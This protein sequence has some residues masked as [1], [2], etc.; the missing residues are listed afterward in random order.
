M[1]G[2]RPVC[3]QFAGRGP[4]RGTGGSAAFTNYCP[5]GLLA[6][7]RVQGLTNHCGTGESARPGWDRPRLAAGNGGR[8]MTIIRGSRTR[9][10]PGIAAAAFLAVLLPAGLASAA[11]ASAGSASAGS[12]A[13]AR[14]GPGVCLVRL[15]PL[16]EPVP[17]GQPAAEDA[18]GQDDPGRQDQ[19]GHRRGH[20]PAVRLLHLR[21]PEPVHP[22]HGRG[23]RPG[24]G[25]RRPHRRHRAPVRGVPG[26]HLGSGPGQPSTARSSGR[27]SAARA[28]W[29]T[30]ARP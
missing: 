18:D 27:R 11:S 16:A 4:G 22:G 19:H 20:Q 17:D 29:S 9:R 25:G 15:L 28:P 12:A 3:G 1:A 2:H 21:D 5:A 13:R 26:R 30:W 24:R 10:L 23:R 7:R 6:A 8:A 14:R